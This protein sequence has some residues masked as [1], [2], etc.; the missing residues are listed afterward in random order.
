[1]IVEARLVEEKNIENPQEEQKLVHDTENPPLTKD[2]EKKELTAN[3]N[4]E[5]SHMNCVSSVLILLM[6]IFFIAGASLWKDGKVFTESHIDA[7]GTMYLIASILYTTHVGVEVLKKKGLGCVHMLMTSL[8]FLAGISWF[9]GACILLSAG[10]FLKDPFNEDLLGDISNVPDTFPDIPDTFPD[11]PDDFPD[12]PDGFPDIPDSFP[13]FPVGSGNRDVNFFRVNFFSGNN[14]F[15]GFYACWLI[16]SL[17]NLVCII[18]ECVKMSE[19]FSMKKKLYKLIA[20]VFVFMAN[21]FILAASSVFLEEG[22]EGYAWE[23]GGTESAS[24]LMVTASVFYLIYGVIISL[25][26][27]IR[28]NDCPSAYHQR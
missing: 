23:F 18:Y 21:L 14:E 2:E 16:G 28:L 4:D 13:S 20:L 17:L 12:I 6:S 27:S 26:T 19:D 10:D 22:L 5:C 24:D 3:T 25:Q 8:G 7:L 11:I 15:N 9:I 1:M